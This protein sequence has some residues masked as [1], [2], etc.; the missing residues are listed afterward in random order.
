MVADEYSDPKK[1]AGA[2]KITP[3]HDFNDFDVGKRHE[4]DGARPI[5]ILDAQGR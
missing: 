2:V 5:N 3:A 1:G 4:A